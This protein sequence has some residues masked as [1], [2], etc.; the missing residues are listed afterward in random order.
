[1]PTACTGKAYADVTIEWLAG[2]HPPGWDSPHPRRRALARADSIAMD[3]H[4]W[5]YVPV[6]AGMLLLR[7]PET[8][9]DAFSLVPP[10]LRTDTDPGGV[11]F[12]E[13]GFDQ[14]RP[15][16]ALKI[17]MALQHLG[18]GT[19]RDLIRHDLHLA[20]H[21]RQAVNATPDLE[22]LASGLSVICLRYHPAGWNGTPAQLDQLNSNILTAVQHCGQ[23][24]IAGTT[25]AGRGALRVCIVNPGAKLDDIDALAV[26]ILEQGARSHL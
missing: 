16:R 10:Y 17:W 8:A 24:F 21:L 25:V 12:S 4:K 13:Y 20:R 23:A 15:F 22:L 26:A 1:M 2:A 5:L 14:T 6:D 19:Y 18:L 3:P 7:R 11:W 9:R